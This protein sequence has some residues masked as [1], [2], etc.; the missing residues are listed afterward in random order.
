MGL[1]ISAAEIFCRSLRLFSHPVS[2]A[3]TATITVKKSPDNNLALGI[4]G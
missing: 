3:D 4:M 1:L 2:K